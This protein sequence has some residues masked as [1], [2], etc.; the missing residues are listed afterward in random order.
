[1]CSTAGWC[2]QMR[3]WRGNRRSLRGDMS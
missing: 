3:S 2:R 1:M